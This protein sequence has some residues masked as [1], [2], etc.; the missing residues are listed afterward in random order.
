MFHE[1]WTITKCRGNT[2]NIY[3]NETKSMYFYGDID[4]SDLKGP[5]KMKNKKKDKVCMQVYRL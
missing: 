5:F 1:Q 3:K 4:K 2:K